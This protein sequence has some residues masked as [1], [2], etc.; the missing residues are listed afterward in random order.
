MARVTKVDRV[1]RR[2]KDLQADKTVWNNHYQYLGELMLT[3]KQNFT[4]DDTTGG[5]FQNDLIFS[6]KPQS[7][8]KVAASSL[9][10]SLWPSSAKSFR[11]V[12]PDVDGLRSST[13]VKNY[14]EKITKRTATILDSAKSGLT[15]AIT[16]YMLDQVV[17]G[18]SGIGV[19]SGP[20]GRPGSPLIRFKPWNVKHMMLDENNDGRVDVVYHV[21]KKSIR[22]VAQEYGVENLSKVSR[23]MLA[24]GEGD[25]KIKI[26]V[27]IEPRIDAD[28]RMFGSKHMPIASLHIE[29][30]TGKIL[31][32]SGFE[33]MPI[34]VARMFKGMDE[35]Y[36]RS[37]GMDA[38]PAAA[39]LNVLR[40]AYNVAVE[41]NLDPPTWSFS[42]TPV[43]GGF[44]D[45]S[46][47]AHM[48]FKPSG[49]LKGSKEMPINPVYTVG[50]LRSAKELM[51]MLV[52]EISDALMVDR[53]LD[54]N[55]D[56]KMTLGEAQIRAKFRGE[57]LGM[58]FARQHHEVFT[59][60]LE[61]SYS[62]L[63]DTGVL[64]VIEGGEQ[65]D[66]LLSQGYLPSDL[67]YIP[68]QIAERLQDPDTDAFEIEYIS[69]ASRI[70]E[71]EK[72]QGIL[73]T[74]DFLNQN[75]DVSQDSVDVINLDKTARI[76]ANLSGAPLEIVRSDEE[77][78]AI[79][80]RRDA[81]IQ[82]QEK[83]EQLVQGAAAMQSMAQANSMS[84]EAV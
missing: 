37:L 25:K 9:L 10:G 41:K 43:A 56:T 50:E 53:L 55:N 51:E 62:V 57:S 52:D 65:E 3:R 15:L 24:D 69:P 4:G 60:M 32:E 70:I 80:D 82:E 72:V 26:L 39:Q 48:V 1:K 35:I 5:E 61:R 23:K 28:P 75:K 42:D 81:R 33:S 12:A 64:G 78:Q 54:L 27:A 21:S 71:A 59:P 38:L 84:R 7:L 67:L 68:E 58:L 49:R 66:K 30:E 18:T 79:R 63:F 14:F 45:N 29:L 77:V 73:T 16:E 2:L 8:A 6:N 20:I 22:N 17:F 36:G 34:F 46:P 76:M 11:Y 47:G 40:Q 83:Q 31:K 44:I 13:L 74:V 19:F